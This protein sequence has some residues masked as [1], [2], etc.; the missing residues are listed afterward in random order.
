MLEKTQIIMSFIVEQKK[1]DC[2][3]N[4]PKKLLKLAQIRT[5]LIVASIKMNMKVL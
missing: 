3:K 5:A 1:W 4:V 2:F